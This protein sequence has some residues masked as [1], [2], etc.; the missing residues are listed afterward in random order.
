MNEDNFDSNISKVHRDVLKYVRPDDSTYATDTQQ[1][2]T[3]QN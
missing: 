2:T 3:I 1:Y